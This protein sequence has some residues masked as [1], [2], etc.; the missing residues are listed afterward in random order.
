MN[1]DN[2]LNKQGQFFECYCLAFTYIQRIVSIINCPY[3]KFF[4][5]KIE[6]FI[7]RIEFLILKIV[8]IVSIVFKKTLIALRYRL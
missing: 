7:F 2:S 6:F 1:R 8:P 4:I 5:F 3:C